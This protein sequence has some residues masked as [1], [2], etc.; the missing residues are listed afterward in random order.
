[1]RNL[2]IERLPTKDNERMLNTEAA[3]AFLNVDPR[4]LESWRLRGNGPRFVR[5]S[6]RCVRYRLSDLIDW[7]ASH[8]ALPR[9]EGIL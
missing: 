7:V 9:E 2:D 5:Y 4:T 6:G 1:M 8:E 3:G